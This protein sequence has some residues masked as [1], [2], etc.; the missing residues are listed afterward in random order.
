[1]TRNQ[2]RQR[3]D[4]FERNQTELFQRVRSHPAYDVQIASQ[5]ISSNKLFLP[6]GVTGRPFCGALK[7]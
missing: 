4:F 1:M 7:L 3:I 5:A 2:S 6:R